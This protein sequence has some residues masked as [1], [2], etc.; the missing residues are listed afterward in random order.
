VRTRDLLDNVEHYRKRGFSK[1][2]MVVS[3]GGA[4]SANHVGILRGFKFPVWYKQDSIANV[5]A[6]NDLVRE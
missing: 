2:M 3:N 5:I 1:G 6:L 4:V